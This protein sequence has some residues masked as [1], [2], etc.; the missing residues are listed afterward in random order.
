MT[1][2]LYTCHKC[3]REVVCEPKKYEE[4]VLYKELV[5]YGSDGELK[6]ITLGKISFCQ[7]CVD[8]S[9][10]S[11]H[12]KSAKK[13]SRNTVKKHVGYWKDEN[14]KN[15]RKIVPKFLNKEPIT[16]EELQAIKNYVLKWIGVVFVRPVNYCKIVEE[17]NRL[18]LLVYVENNLKRL[19]IEP[20]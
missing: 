15:L 9:E 16:D 12:W 2:F 6:T 18:E 17:C 1:P 8:K 4:R 20:F 11:G 10:Q 19:E 5:H 7:Y 3:H 13:S 14:H